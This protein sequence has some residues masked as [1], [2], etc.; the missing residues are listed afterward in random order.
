[1]KFAELSLPYLR[2]E[3]FSSCFALNRNTARAGSECGLK[4]S[5][6]NSEGRA[7]HSLFCVCCSI[8]IDGSIVSGN[9]VSGTTNLRGQDYDLRGGDL[10]DVLILV[11]YLTWRGRLITNLSLYHP[12][13]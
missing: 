11:P 2:Q 7:N 10:M 5:D 13:D 8:K 12:L 9:I 3:F 1:M 6:R 4:F